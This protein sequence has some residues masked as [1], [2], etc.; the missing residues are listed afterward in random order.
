METQIFRGTLERGTFAESK[1]ELK[2][3]ETG[4]KNQIEDDKV[5]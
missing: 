3:D 2:K 5:R 1:Q 4:K